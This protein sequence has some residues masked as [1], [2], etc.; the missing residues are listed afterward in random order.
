MLLFV[1][2]AL[3]VLALLKEDVRALGVKQ[4]VL[5]ELPLLSCGRASTF[6]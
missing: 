6:K 1:G 5:L 2:D 3:I 4:D